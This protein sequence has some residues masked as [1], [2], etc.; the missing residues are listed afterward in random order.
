MLNNIILNTDSYK[1]SHYLQYPPET[2]YV[3]SYIESRGGR[4]NKTLFFG[5][6]MFIQ[7][8]LSNQITRQNIEEAKQFFEAHGEPFNE[9]GWR[10]IVDEHA[11]LLPVQ[12]YA[13]PEGT[14]VPTGNVLLTIQNTDPAVPW[15]TQYLE[16]ALLRAIW[17]PTTVATQSWSIK[18]VIRK[19]MEKTADTT[20]S[21]DFKLHDFGARGVS[22]AESAAIGGA[23]HLVNFRG[24]DNVEGILAANRFYYERMSGF[25]IPA[26]EHSTILAWGRES[27]AF[28][29]MLDKFAKPGKPV[30]VVSDTFDL[31]N[32]IDTWGYELKDEIVKSGATVVIRPDSGD[33]VAVPVLAVQRL[34]KH[35]GHTI[36]TKGFRVLNNV[37]VIQGDGVDGSAIYSIL[38]NLA[39]LGYSAN[40]ITFGMGGGLLQKVD[41][42]TQKFAMKAS[43]I[44]GA[45]KWR[46]VRKNPQT[47]PGKASKSGKFALIRDEGGKFG[48]IPLASQEGNNLLRCVFLNG[49]SV[50]RDD[51]KGIRERA[52]SSS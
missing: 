43:A 34:D 28:R 8:Y 33:P 39:T 14:V 51:L 18:Q 12:I 47:D 24:S 31:W 6:Q 37:C 22:S 23:A 38:D 41:R 13:V 45:G 44:C 3:Y 49:V 30:A 7:Q 17:Y 9:A 50:I 40:N 26:A 19:F 16:T 48:T 20:C 27:E 52:N 4:Y 29:N 21:L 5:L 15:L 46:G 11:G 32:A 1:A 35:F 10:H 36:N 42:D 2:E 25:S